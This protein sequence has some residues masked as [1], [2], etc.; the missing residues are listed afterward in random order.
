MVQTEGIL[1]INMNKIIVTVTL[2]LLAGIAWRWDTSD[3]T[4][5]QVGRIEARNAAS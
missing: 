5:N 1:M 3:L 2:S 4:Y